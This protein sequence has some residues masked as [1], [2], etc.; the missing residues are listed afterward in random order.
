V[1]PGTKMQKISN[2]VTYDEMHQNPKS[3]KRKEYLKDWLK[4]N[5]RKA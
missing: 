4:T 1:I 2:E 3:I 5:L